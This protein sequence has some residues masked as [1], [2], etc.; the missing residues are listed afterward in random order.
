M[1]SARLLICGDLVITDDKYSKDKIDKQIVDLFSSSDWNIANLECP[2][3][4][5]KEKIKKTGPHLK[6]A[7]VPIAQILK[8]LNVNLV[9]LANNH[10]LDYGEKGLIDTLSF[11]KENNIETVGAGIDVEAAKKSIRRTI[12]GHKIAIVNFAENEWASASE[13][14]AGANPMD[15]IDNVK[16]I[17]AEKAI[18][19]I[20]IVIVHGGHEYYN[21]P[22][23]RMQKQYR[24]YAEQGADIVVGHHTH[25]VNGHEVHNGIPIYYSTG[26]FLFTKP[27]SY[28]DWYKGIVLDVCIDEHRKIS[29]KVNFVIQEKS[30]YSLRLADGKEDEELK[31]RFKKYSNIISD[32]ANLQLTS[33]IGLQ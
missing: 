14:V 22:S 6:G 13:K 23:P 25:C 10:I 19:D 7:A 3:T 1:K 20:V 4:S 32:S 33:I 16:Q 18:S 5:E 2:V 26:N 8:I 11:C 12:N 29:V 9:T 15:L 28:E 17:Q 24:F 31:N 21:L 30:N 27:S